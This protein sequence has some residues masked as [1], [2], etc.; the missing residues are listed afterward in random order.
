MIKIYKIEKSKYYCNEYKVYN[1]ML[2]TETERGFGCGKVFEGTYS[3]C[4]NERKRILNEKG[5]VLKR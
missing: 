2:Y 5:K 4:M 1:L 3:E